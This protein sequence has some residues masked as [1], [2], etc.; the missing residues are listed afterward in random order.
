MTATKTTTAADHGTLELQPADDAQSLV[1]AALPGPG[2]ARQ[3]TARLPAGDLV[4]RA[5]ENLP[6]EHRSLIRWLHAHAFAQNWTLET[7]AAAIKRDPNTLYQVFTGRHQASKTAIC[8]E[9]LRLQTITLKREGTEKVGY[10]KTRLTKRIWD[11]C[12]ATL[13]HQRISLIIGDTQ[14][15]KTTALKEYAK[16]HNH[17]ETIYV[18]MPSGGTLGHFLEELARALRILGRHREMDL[19][20]RILEAFDAKMLLIVDEAHQCLIAAASSPHGSLRSIKT[21][22][23]IR[24]IHDRTGAGIII[25]ATPIFAREM[26]DGK[27]SGVL[28]QIYNRRLIN[29]RLPRKPTTGDL[30]AFAAAYGLPPAEGKAADLQDRIATGQSLGAWL[31]LLRMASG[32]AHRRKTTL[33]WPIVQ[34]AARQLAALESGTFE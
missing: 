1:P 20:R 30:S 19:R 18:S 9:I 11:V 2:H 23:F 22:E 8:E 13:T 6:D 27:F 16:E 25:S 31:T 21:L 24:E 33:T 28:A 10:I 29:L 17:G 5:T 12:Q 32:L 15:G 7:T 26:E 3:T 4:N 34:D 14:I